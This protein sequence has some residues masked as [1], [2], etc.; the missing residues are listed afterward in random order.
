MARPFCKPR[1][2]DMQPG[3]P[4]DAGKSFD[5]IGNAAPE[6]VAGATHRVVA[7]SLCAKRGAR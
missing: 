1:Q 7:A 2:T 3:E 6:P 5:C 4:A